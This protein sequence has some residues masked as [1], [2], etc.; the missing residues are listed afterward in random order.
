MT[1][2]VFNTNF[3]DDLIKSKEK[4]V[5]E[6]IKNLM[7][8]KEEFKKVSHPLAKEA[9]AE[10]ILDL[11]S[12][13]KDNINKIQ[14][15]IEKN[16]YNETDRLLNNWRLNSNDSIIFTRK[17]IVSLHEL[18]KYYPDNAN[19]LY[20]KFRSPEVLSFD[21][22]RDSINFKVFL[23]KLKIDG[24]CTLMVELSR[25]NMFEYEIKNSKIGYYY[26]SIF[27]YTL[28]KLL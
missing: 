1:S 27:N 9:L 17:N 20:W 4:E 22:N 7:E 26:V 12:I 28:S 24:I 23:G 10:G 25:K 18:K 5:N 6:N 13:L 3:S 19:D 21:K 14:K 16:I 15:L 2:L 11:E 8:L